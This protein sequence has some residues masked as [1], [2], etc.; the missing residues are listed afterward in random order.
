M[1]CFAYR[2]SQGVCELL[3][4]HL[5]STYFLASTRWETG[6]LSLKISR[7]LGLEREEVRESILLAALLHDIGKAATKFQ[8]E[9]QK[10][11]CESFPQHYLTSAFYV[12]YI[13]E[14]SLKFNLT[15]EKIKKLLKGEEVGCRE[16]LIGLIVL[17]PVAFHHY[18]QVWGYS[19]Y[20]A[21]K[22][23]VMPIHEACRCCFK[24]LG[25]FVQHNFTMLKDVGHHLKSLP[26]E[27]S[28]LKR[29]SSS[30]IFVRNI[31]NVIIE[32]VRPRSI[33]SSAIEAVTGIVN[34]CDG[35]VARLHRAQPRKL[36]GS[37]KLLSERGS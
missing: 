12:H 9:C 6:A 8:E 34:L 26:D 11:S 21:K 1:S 10:G 29:T 25:E 27:L 28:A 3:F 30:E 31:E 36:N 19:S 35:Y 24:Q 33:L 15:S 18:H 20:S 16:E 23:F 2:D 5:V 37:E 17:Y 22:G 7:V 14:K 4:N 13:L 32:V